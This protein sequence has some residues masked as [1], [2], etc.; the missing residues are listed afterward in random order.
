MIGDPDA[1]LYAEPAVLG[2]T[3]AGL[4]LFVDDNAAVLH[5]AVEAGAQQVQP[6]TEMFYGS[7]SASV[8]DPYGHVWVLLV[9]KED[10]ETSEMERRG[11]AFFNRQAPAENRGL[12]PAA[13]PP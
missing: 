4:H 8:R 5:R 12:G 6:P 3:S 11:K 9:W 2:R 13:I 7:S 1:D 10:L